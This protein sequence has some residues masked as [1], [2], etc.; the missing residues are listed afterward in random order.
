MFDNKQSSS[1]IQDKND[2]RVPIMFLSA[3]TA[4]FL[5]P[6]LLE[7]LYDALVQHP[8]DTNRY[9]AV[10]ICPSFHLVLVLPLCTYVSSIQS[11]SPAPRGR[12]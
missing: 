6:F 5:L 2:L 9:H 4:S 12:R 8:T 7:L 1:Q 3:L 10:A 11:S